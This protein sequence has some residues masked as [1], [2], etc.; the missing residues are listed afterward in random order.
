M[1]RRNPLRHAGSGPP[2]STP[3]QSA[4]TRAT[5]SSWKTSSTV[6]NTIPIALM[7]FPF[8]PGGSRRASSVGLRG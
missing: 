5:R 1:T 2:A 7:P 6:D 8:R 4:T 3:I